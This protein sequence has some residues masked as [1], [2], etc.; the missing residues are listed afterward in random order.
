MKQ[1]FTEHTELPRQKLLN[2]AEAVNQ[3]SKEQ[4]LELATEGFKKIFKPSQL[5]KP[6]ILNWS[7]FS[8]QG[9]ENC[10]IRIDLDPGQL[11]GTD[12]EQMYGI[13]N[14]IYRKHR[15]PI[16]FLIRDSDSTFQHECIH[17]SQFLFDKL[18]PLSG[19]EYEQLFGMVSFDHTGVCDIFNQLYSKEVCSAFIVRFAV[20]Q[21]WTEIEAVH[22]TQYENYSQLLER[23]YRSAILLG[24]IEHFH[25]RYNMPEEFMLAARE[26]TAN[27]LEQMEHDVTWMRELRKNLKTS[28]Y[29]DVL[30]EHEE[31]EVN[32]MFGPIEDEEDDT[33]DLDSE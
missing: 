13:T 17:A 15:I 28:F 16:I 30:L 26:K 5:T 1:K 18:Y 27:Y 9:V 23:A 12:L 22:T 33:I 25:S 31:W 19:D 8:L 11:E 29:D 6:N 32:Q 10:G 14:T 21:F 2:A 7:F 3:L 4:V 20:F 24:T